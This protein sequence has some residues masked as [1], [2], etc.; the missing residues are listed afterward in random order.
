MAQESFLLPVMPDVLEQWRYYI[1]HLHL[2]PDDLVL[3]VGCNCGDA[4][5]YIT[6]LH[7]EIRQIIGL[8]NSSV[9]LERAKKRWGEN[10]KIQFIEG[11]ATQLPFSD[12]T[13][14]KVLCVDTL[15]WVKPPEAGLREIFRVL[16]PGGIALIIH[17]D[18]DSQIFSGKKIQLTRKIV[19]AFSDSGAYGTIGRDL[20]GLCKRSGFSNV[21]T[22]VYTLTNQYFKEDH[23]AKKIAEMMGDWLRQKNLITEDE[24]NEWIDDLEEQSRRGEFFYSVNRY[25]CI[26]SK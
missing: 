4:D 19:H 14:D 13:F 26:C 8:D 17:T 9:R 25:L 16:K 6:S 21:V 11:D 24:W 2:Q 5:Q 18:F 20:K 1:G 23:Y 3:D 10:S 22:D 12:H 15:E 7:P